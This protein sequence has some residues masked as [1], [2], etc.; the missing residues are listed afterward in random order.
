MAL[1]MVEIFRN[2]NLIATTG[3]LMILCASSSYSLAFSE[4]EKQLQGKLFP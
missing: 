2:P 3:S 4:I 1:V